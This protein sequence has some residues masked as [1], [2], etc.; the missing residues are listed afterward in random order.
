MPKKKT[1]AWKDNPSYKNPNAGVPISEHP[2]S[3][4]FDPNEYLEYSVENPEGK[5]IGTS[6]PIGTLRP[7]PKTKK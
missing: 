7:Y 4:N 6:T 3:A 2:N 5:P 1:P